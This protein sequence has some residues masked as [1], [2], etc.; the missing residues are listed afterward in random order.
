[1]ALTRASFPRDLTE[2]LN[3]HFGMEYASR[4]PEWQHVFETYSSDKA[5]EED[6]LMT[7]F[8]PA[9]LK[10]EGESYIEDEARQ[11]WTARYQHVTVGMKFSITQEAL[12]D[13]LYMQLG[14]R[15]AR[16]MARSMAETKE[17][18]AANILN[19]AFNSSYKGGDGVE[20]CSTAHPSLY[21]GSFSN[22]LATPA[23]L[24]ETALE[25]LAIMVRMATDDRGLPIALKVKKLVI[26][27][28]LEYVAARLLKSEYRTGTNENDVN[29][30]KSLGVF[31]TQPVVLT[32]LTDPSAFFIL[33]DCMDGL[34]HFNRKSLEKGS[35]EDP[36]TGNLNFRA[37]MRFS[38]GWSDPR[39]V[40]GSP[41]S[42]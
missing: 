35:D 36:N 39:S 11:G 41:C 19:R 8:G 22:E 13:N 5:F 28:Q 32:R 40:W 29:A 37:R 15:Y 3:A 18:M 42:S 17:V 16:A 9:P 6:V 12:E 1:M 21:A 27:P 31:P 38:L 25:D 26:P 23:D 33:S 10:G 14:S 30:I 34:K 24:S 7:G 20:L 4:P 2:G